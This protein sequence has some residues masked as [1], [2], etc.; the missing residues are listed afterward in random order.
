MS[1]QITVLPAGETY[2][3]EKGESLLNAAIENGIMLPHACKSGCCG[4]CKARLVNGQTTEVNAQAALNSKDNNQQDILLCC[5]S[6]ESDI[7]FYLPGY[8]GKNNQPAQ[9]LAA[10]IDDIRYCANV[11]IVSLKLAPK[12]HFNFTAGQYID[13]VLPNNL[14]RSYSI[15][16]FNA[17]T[18]Q[19]VI[20]VR[21]HSGGVFSEQLFD[22][23]LQPKDIIHIHGPLGCFQLNWRHQPLIM[24]ASGTGIAPIE[25]M[26]TALTQQQYQQAVY[27]YWG[28]AAEEN[29]YDSALLD[30]LCGSLAQAQWTAVLSRA[31]TTWQGA[32]G[33][34]QDIALAKHPDMSNYAV[35]ACGNPQMIAHAQNLFTS[36]A[37]LAED[38]FFADN[39]T[40]AA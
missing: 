18:R 23:R 19:L 32:Q 14:R 1:Y 31:S 21:R 40:P 9:T 20:H 17:D 34:I 30:E 4:A 7:T 25:A 36:Q 37:S 22:G 12:K 5:Q 39:F 24:L 33:Y 15:A 2:C 16:R 29:L 35:Y 13:I 26:L 3:A 28:V 11:A 6:A 38:A 10:R 27:V 8:Q